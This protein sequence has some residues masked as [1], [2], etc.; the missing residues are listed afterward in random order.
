M[1][2]QRTP[3]TLAL[4]LAA[5]VFVPS[6]AA[7]TQ[8]MDPEHSFFT[9]HVFKAGVFSAFG[10]AHEVRAPVAAGVIHEGNPA[11]VELRVDARQ[12]RVLDP[13]LSQKDRAEVQET[14]LGPKVLDTTRFPEIRFHSTKV[15]KSGPDHWQVRG[16]LTLHGQTRPV[17]VDVRSEAGRY[18]GTATFKQSAFGITPF[19]AAGGTV[20]VKDEVKVDF[21][22]AVRN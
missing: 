11:S 15:E 10:H 18:L 5:M 3:I 4:I 16:D 7:Q 14:M 6:L 1:N 13:D 9:V 21:D 8:E 17:L 22:I 20:K 12:L 2:V 19:R